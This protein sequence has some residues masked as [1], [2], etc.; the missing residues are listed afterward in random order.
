MEDFG[1]KVEILEK[2][3]LLR[4]FDYDEWYIIGGEVDGARTI[5][6]GQRALDEALENGLR[7]LR[8]CGEAACFFEHKKEKE[9]M[10]FE[11]M[12]GRK[13]D[14][15]VTLL[16]AYNVKHAK[17]L[18]EKIFFDLIKA[19]GPVVTTSFALEINFEDFFATITN[20]VLERVFGEK[21]KETLLRLLCE[22]QSLTLHKIGEDPR[23]FVEGL[24]EL[25]GS[26]AKVVTLAVVEQ[27]H[28]KMGIT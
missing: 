4:I 24:E 22:G 16:C 15:H 7:G 10:E 5:T 25:L 23:S 2:D 11:L 6:L 26:G 1:L 17:S 18:E 20:E 21:G 9:L 27:M 3:G 14:P 8:A 13:I 19:H 12:M 28:A